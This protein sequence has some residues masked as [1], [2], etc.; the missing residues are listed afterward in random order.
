[1]KIKSKRVWIAGMFHP[2]VIEIENGS[3]KRIGT[4]QEK[5]DVNYDNLRIVP[6]FIDIHC[7]GAYGFD[8]N[9]ADDKGLR[10]WS[11]HIVKE[12]VTG[13][14][15]TT[16]TQSHEVLSKAVKNVVSVCESDYEGAEI[17]GIHLEGPYLSVKQKGAQP[18]EFIRPADIEEFKQLQKDAKGKIKYITIAPENDKDYALIRYC[19]THGVTVSM[20]HS[21]ATLAQVK[22]AY[23]NGAKC[24]THV[25]NGMSGFHHRNNGMAGAALRLRDIY[26]EIICDMKHST[27][28]AVNI[29]FHAKGVHRAIMVTDS[30][31]CK[32]CEPGSIFYFGGNEISVQKDGSARLNDGTLAGSTLKMNEGLRNLVEIAMVPFE[33]ALNSCT[34]NPAELLGIADRK[35]YIRAGNDADLVILEDDYSIHDVYC[36]GKQY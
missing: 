33:S 12:G 19:S 26:G 25:Y 28:E 8:T 20:G 1:M 3:I 18:E 29:F 36:K 9:D 32:G 17:L 5:S 21:S 30:L 24:M 16:I 6:G 15:C 4:Y 23:A 31:N 35:G 34:S 22:M 10:Y 27:P 2:A 11:K 13:F 14:L 7:H